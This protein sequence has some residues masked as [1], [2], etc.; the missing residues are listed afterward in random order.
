[1]LLIVARAPLMMAGIL[2]L[3]TGWR[4]FLT[5]RRWAKSHR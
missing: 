2:V 1:V 3:L 5:Y 4:M